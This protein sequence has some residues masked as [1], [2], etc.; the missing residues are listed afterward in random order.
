MTRKSQR[1]LERAVDDL[2]AAQSASKTE[3]DLTET[4]ARAIREYELY[5]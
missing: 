4:Q 1:E 5:C 3:V 2:S